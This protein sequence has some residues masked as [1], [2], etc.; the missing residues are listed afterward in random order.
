M[1]GDGGV[2]RVPVTHFSGAGAGAPAPGADGSPTDPVRAMGQA[3]TK[4]YVDNEYNCIDLS[5]PLGEFL[6]GGY[7]ALFAND[8]E[9]GLEQASSNDMVLSPAIDA[10]MRWRAARQYYAPLLC[11]DA[12]ED[13]DNLPEDDRADE[14]ITA[15]IVNAI[16][17]AADSCATTHDLG[18]TR[19]MLAWRAVAVMLFGDDDGT[20]SSLASERVRGCLTFEVQF[21]SYIEVT[22]SP[23]VFTADMESTVAGLVPVGQAKRLGLFI[24]DD[25]DGVGTGP[26]SYTPRLEMTTN[27][28]CPVDVT[29]V[30]AHPASALLPD[31]PIPDPIRQVPLGVASGADAGVNQSGGEAGEVSLIFFPLAGSE[32]FETSCTDLLGGPNPDGA[33]GPWTFNGI[34]EEEMNSEWDGFTI[35]LDRGTGKLYGRATYQR[36]ETRPSATIY[37]E[38]TFDLFHAAPRVP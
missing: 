7:Q 19:Y 34:H 32:Y 24:A 31:V 17:T 38:T 29:R 16:D 14:L 13:I 6:I 9:P 10:A 30:E 5:H 8:V 27:G 18:E 15:G 33:W 2:V 1:E 35:K 22:D 37:E 11:E 12:A 23:V 3:L 25:D 20:W 4:A 28:G 26:L 21:H 36:T